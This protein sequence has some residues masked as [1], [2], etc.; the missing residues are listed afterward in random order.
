MSKYNIGNIPIRVISQ[1]KVD[2]SKYVLVN[3][4]GGCIEMAVPYGL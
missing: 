4:T 2:Y 3:H 1:C